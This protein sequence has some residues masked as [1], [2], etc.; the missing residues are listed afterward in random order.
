MG[1]SQGS[2]RAVRGGSRG[3]RGGGGRGESESRSGSED[4]SGSGGWSESGG[5]GG[6]AHAGGRA[7]ARTGGRARRRAPERPES[8]RK[9]LPQALVVA[10]LAGGTSAFVVHDKAVTLSVE[11]RPRTVHTFAGSVDELLAEEGVR[12]G[13]HDAVAPA[14]GEALANGEDVAVRRG[15]PVELTLD[16]ERRTVWTTARTVAGALREWGVRA[17]GAYLST[18]RHAGIGREG[19]TLAVRTERSLTV[20]ADG[21]RHSLRTNAATVGEA[22]GAAGVV[23]RGEDTTSVPRDGFPRDGQTITVMRIAGKEKIREETIAFET[24][25]REDPE[26]TR[27]STVVARAGRQGVRRVT[28]HQRTVNGLAEKPRRVGTKVVQKPRSQIIR[29]GTKVLPAAV[30]GAEALNWQALAQCESGGRSGLVDSS[31]TY[32]GLYQFDTQT[33]QSLGGTGRP[34]NAPPAE[35]TYRAKKLYVQRGA[36]PWPVCGRKLHQ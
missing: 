12:L 32:G 19:I 31:G 22:V 30:Q 29:I 10:F 3:Q 2:H 6:G 24:V 25:H 28:Y 15:R 23:L 34:Q 11:G 33:W 4:R 9:L 8:L 14:P 18:G 26:L 35:Q 27:G 36:S 13:A 21:Q 17:E 1:R 7:H 5:R 20:L 16:G